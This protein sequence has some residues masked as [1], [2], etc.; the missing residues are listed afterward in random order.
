MNMNL[1]ANQ[2][3]FDLEVGP[4]AP[5]ELAVVAWQAEEAISRPFELEVEVASSTEDPSVD[6]AALVGQDATLTIHLGALDQRTWNGIVARV[7]AWDAGSGAGRQRY[8]LT[9]V[10]RVHRLSLIRRSR[11]FQNLSVPEIVARVLSAAGV[12]HRLDLAERYGKRDYCVQ[13]RESDLAFLSRLLEEEGI[14]YFFEHE[15]AAHTMVLADHPTTHVGIAGGDTLVFRPP[16][17]MTPTEDAIEQLSIGLEMRPGAVVLRDYSFKAP[18]LDLSARQVADGADDAL[19]VYDYPGEY[20][21]PAV[22]KALARV[23]LE[24]LR[25]DA[26]VASGTSRCRRLSAGAV[27]EL[28][29]HPLDTF[30]RRYLLRS[31][32]HVGR[33][34]EALP[35]A[36]AIAPADAYRAE[37]L[38]QPA[39]VPFRPARVTERP[40]IPGPQTATVVGTAG[41]EIDPDE[42][43]RVKVQFHWDREGQRD[44]R[45]SCWIR[46]SQAW[47]GPGWGALYLPRIGQE[48]I[49][50]FLE[51]DPDRPIITGR[52]YNGHNPPPVSLP[53]DKTR[54]TLR[55]SSS[56]GGNGS[57]ELAFEDAAGAEKVYLHAQKDLEIHVENDKT[58]R[59]GGNEALFVKKDRKKDV[60][61]KQELHVGK[62]DVS[63]VDGEQSLRVKLDRHVQV[64]GS[65]SETIAGT[66]TIQVGGNHALTIAL[67]SLENVGLGK[68]LN[69]GGGYAVNVV[70]A[71]MENVGGMRMENVAGSKSEK[72]VGK[73]TETIVK[74]SR[75]L[76]V[77]GSMTDDVGKDHKLNVKKNFMVTVGEQLTHSAGQSLAIKA[78][79]IVF[80]GEDELSIKVGAVTVSFKKDGTTV[81]KAKKVEMTASGDVVIKG[82]KISEN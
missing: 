57:N 63:V 30:N 71:M 44:A 7:G 79:D 74:G 80:T 38:C 19:E 15:A 59:I 25:Q 14:C 53:A 23:R 55:S 12:A 40:I 75:A 70:G 35:H 81:V 76:K 29:E 69:V 13:Y 39:E 16:S 78:K 34:P 28:A 6:P 17:L 2:A 5:G 72:V 46:V 21:A 32:R 61:G 18:A 8:R 49:V 47:A 54:S 66:Q 65:H 24:E 51:G 10:P 27:F 3:E 43:G 52:V 37:L 11:I 48:V 22:G 26:D 82:S 67:G 45:S 20:V 64:D 31:V 56:L 42:H 62:D 9:I 60:S 36:A 50:E 73:K 41:E 77:G 4:H 33:Q 58:Q 68:A 1:A